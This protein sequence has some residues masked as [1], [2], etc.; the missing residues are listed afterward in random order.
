MLFLYAGFA[1]AAV[2]LATAIF[3]YLYARRKA[4]V[5]IAAR[6]E[7]ER[8]RRAVLDDFGDGAVWQMGQLAPNAMESKERAYPALT[9]RGILPRILVSPLLRILGPRE[10]TTLAGLILSGPAAA[11]TSNSVN[12]QG[13]VL[14]PGDVINFQ[15]GAATAFHFERYGHSALYLGV[16][17][18]T[19]QREFL[20]FTTTKGGMTEYVLGSPQPFYGRILNEKNFFTANLKSHATF[21]VFR[22]KGSP[23]IDQR[24]MFRE[25]KVI[26]FHKSWGFSGVVCSSA[27]ADV[28]SKATGMKIGGFTPNDLTRGQ[29][30]RHPDLAEGQH[31]S[32]RGALQDA[33]HDDA[34]TPYSDNPPYSD[35]PPY[36]DNPAPPH[37][38][39]PHG[40]SL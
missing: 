21:D 40:D 17:P 39:I 38:D 3:V 14:Q 1:L 30:E 34:P 22:L 29:F 8:R 20:D 2:F 6:L 25:A 10:A 32:I 16:D 18:Q 5:Q 26:S 7:L 19:H 27:V 35:S 31:I 24:A 9:R 37:T 4:A 36:S 12:Y 23:T 28:L 11:Q 33:E 15:G 13:I